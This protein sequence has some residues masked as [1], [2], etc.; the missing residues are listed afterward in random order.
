MRAHG[1]VR[2]V[3]TAALLVGVVGCTRA[4]DP[5]LVTNELDVPIRY[6]RGFDADEPSYSTVQNTVS[7]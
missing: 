7:F 5:F 3:L 2:I 4:D 1:F 6:W